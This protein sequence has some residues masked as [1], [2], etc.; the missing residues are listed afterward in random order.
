MAWRK[1][2]PDNLHRGQALLLFE[3]R[4]TKDK[5]YLLKLSDLRPIP[6]VPSEER[7]GF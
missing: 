4:E 7:N 6:E 2:R 5:T 1:E 3:W